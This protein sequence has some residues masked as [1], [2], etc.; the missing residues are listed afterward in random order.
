MNL[1][2]WQDNESDWHGHIMLTFRAFLLSD[3]ALVTEQQNG[4]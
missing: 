4:W 2:E 1:N 3:N